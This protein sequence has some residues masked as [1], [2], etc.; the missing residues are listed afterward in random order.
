MLPQ[1]SAY[2]CEP[3][4]PAPHTHCRAGLPPVPSPQ[5]R[6]HTHTPLLINVMTFY[7]KQGSWTGRFG[8][9]HALGSIPSSFYSP[10]HY[11]DPTHIMKK[12]RHGLS[13]GGLFCL[14]SSLLKVIY[15][16][17]SYLLMAARTLDLVQN[18]FYT[19]FTTHH[20][21]PPPPPHISTF[22]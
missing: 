6:L 20:L 1:I 7:I 12:G 15:T 21:P 13:R 18:R 19:Q 17:S 14:S 5:D 4:P 11:H 3:D 8:M 16:M 10:T 22:F 2:Y 9:D